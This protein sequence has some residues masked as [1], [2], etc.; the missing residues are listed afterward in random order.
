MKLGHR[1]Y[2]KCAIPIGEVVYK[3]LRQENI[4]RDP[5]NISIDRDGY[6]NVNNYLLCID[7]LGDLTILLNYILVSDNIYFTIPSNFFAMRCIS[8]TST[9]DFSM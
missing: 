6:Y 9:L 8:T 5:C 3:I 1:Y 7:S 4:H 2:Q